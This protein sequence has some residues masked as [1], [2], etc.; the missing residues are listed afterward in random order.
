MNI[1]TRQAGRQRGHNVTDVDYDREQ[2]RQGVEHHL[3][4]GRFP[5]T[6]LYGDGKAG[7]RIAD[8]LARASLD[9]NKTLA[10]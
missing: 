7:P 3:K 10:Y 5:R 4:N 6:S 8:L 9:I 1:G 2:I